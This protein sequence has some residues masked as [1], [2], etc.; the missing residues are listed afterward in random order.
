LC[1]VRKIK[2]D[3]IILDFDMVQAEAGWV[4]LQLLKMEDATAVIPVVIYTTALTLSFEIEGYLAA[5]HI[6]MVQKPLDVEALIV[7]IKENFTRNLVLPILVVED[8]EDIS[9]NITAILQLSGYLTMTAS[10]GR[11]ALDAIAQSRYALILLD[12]SMPVMNGL[13]FIAAYVHQPEPH[14]PIII[15]SARS[16]LVTER[17]PEFVMDVLPKPFELNQL[18]ELVGKYALP[19]EG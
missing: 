13:E 16:D 14:S 1:E 8:N 11:L 5:Q 10:N 7:T 18:V 15:F 6:S 4:F 2:P 19:V 3:L 9:D 12:I 17:L